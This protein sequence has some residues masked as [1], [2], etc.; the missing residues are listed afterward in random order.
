[1]GA[2]L[3]VA[4]CCSRF[5]LA[6]FQ[7][8]FQVLYVNSFLVLWHGSKFQCAVLKDSK[9]QH[10]RWSHYPNIFR[11]LWIGENL[12]EAGKILR[13]TTR[14]GEALLGDG[15]P[16]LVKVGKPRSQRLA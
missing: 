6:F 9:G 16:R 15:V 1:M 7:L 3:V 11:I 12:K 14:D 10:V 5:R 2:Y 8:D 13:G 4:R